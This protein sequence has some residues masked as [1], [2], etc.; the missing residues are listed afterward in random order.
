MILQHALM[1]QLMQQ[2]GSAA[3]AD[4]GTASD[5]QRST[6]D[7]GEAATQSA[8]PGLVP[9]TAQGS[10]TGAPDLPALQPII[11]GPKPKARPKAKPSHSQ[12]AAG[13]VGRVQGPQILTGAIVQEQVTPAGGMTMVGQQESS[14][15]FWSSNGDI[16]CNYMPTPIDCSKDL[17]MNL[18][19]DADQ[20]Q[21]RNA[22]AP[23]MA[24]ISPDAYVVQPIYV[25]GGDDEGAKTREVCYLHAARRAVSAT[26]GIHNRSASLLYDTAPL[27]EIREA[28]MLEQL[29]V[30]GWMQGTNFFGIGQWRSLLTSARVRD[31][32]ARRPRRLT[33]CFLL[34]GSRFL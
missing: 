13:T 16:G 34:S 23:P 4:G 24:I 3:V 5:L 26:L 14:R 6:L 17:N 2:Q 7:Q 27:S 25:I 19:E 18:V 31:R 29:S 10:S 28:A 9:G 1:E 20:R 8:E 32:P 22:D 12:L 15:T 30:K 21:K 11:A 33:A